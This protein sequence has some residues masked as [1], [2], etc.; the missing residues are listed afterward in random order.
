MLRSENVSFF[1]IFSTIALGLSYL[2]DIRIDS[3]RNAIKYVDN[4]QI[5]TAYVA[6]RAKITRD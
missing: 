6:T 5:A 1:N 2:L 4:W 3:C